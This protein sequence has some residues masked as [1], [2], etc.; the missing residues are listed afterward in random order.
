LRGK[1]GFGFDPLFVPEGYEQT[2]A[3]MPAN[4]KNSISHRAMALK[5]AKERWGFILSKGENDWPRIVSPE[6]RAK[7]RH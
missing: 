6:Q 1:Q 4:L 7:L 2:F 3:E 5:L